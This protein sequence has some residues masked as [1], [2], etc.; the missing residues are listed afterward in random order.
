LIPTTTSPLD[1]ELVN[2]T[3]LAWKSITGSWPRFAEP[4]LGQLGNRSPEELGQTGATSEKTLE[5][6]PKF[7]PVAGLQP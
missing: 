2:S 1:V 5:F 4:S 3:L 7:Q 6:L